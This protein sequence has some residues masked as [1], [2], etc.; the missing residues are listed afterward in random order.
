M[1]AKTFFI[2]KLTTLGTGLTIGRTAGILAVEAMGKAR[3]NAPKQNKYSDG[4][5]PLNKKDPALPT[6]SKLGTLV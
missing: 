5:D 1:D 4:I 3:A 2:P 6:L